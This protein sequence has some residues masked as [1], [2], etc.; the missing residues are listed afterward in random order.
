[1]G[2]AGLRVEVAQ[3]GLGHGRAILDGRQDAGQGETIARQG[4]LDEG[5]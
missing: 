4:R 3:G 1:V 2:A 5:I